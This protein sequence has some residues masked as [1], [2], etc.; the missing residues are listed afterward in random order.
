MVVYTAKVKKPAKKTKKAAPT[1]AKIR[2]EIISKKDDKNRQAWIMT[3]CVKVGW[4]QHYGSPTEP[5][6]YI[7]INCPVSPKE[8]EEI[9]VLLKEFEANC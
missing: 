5:R 6:T 8:Y 2:L 4:V 3:G 7:T 9:G 1:A